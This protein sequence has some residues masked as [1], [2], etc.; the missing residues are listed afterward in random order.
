MSPLNSRKSRE[1]GALL[2][3]L[4]TGEGLGEGVPRSSHNAPSRSPSTRSS[5]VTRHSLLVTLLATGGALA[6]YN[7][8]LSWQAGPLRSALP[9]ETN[10]YRWSRTGE[11]INVFYKLIG[12]QQDVPL[13]LVHGIDA[14]ASS[15]EWRYVA[16]RL[17]ETHR[18]FAVDLPGFGLS[19][20]P[21]R[22]YS[23]ADYVDFLDDFL[24]EVVGEPAT[25]LASSLSAAY[26]IAVASRSPARVRSLLLICP[27]GLEHLAD[28]PTRWQHALGTLLRLPIV[29]TALYNVL[30]S[31]QSIGYFLCE[32]TFADPALATPELIDAYY[33][34]SHQEGARFAPAAFVS[35]ALNLS[36]REIYPSLTQPILIVWGREAKITP[37]SDANRF[38]QSRRQS[39]LKV[40]DRCGLLPHVEKPAEFLEVATKALV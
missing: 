21:S 10:F 27:T 32:R 24:R 9:G 22:A 26:A 19:D 16:G 28:P 8:W 15:G 23:A 37:V 31:R 39:R 29:G 6:A 2:S 40:L 14:A 36:V 30:V 17:T 11:R 34:T 20:R 35:G 18:V 1:R 7:T 33:R 4:P 25:L 13:V 3:P 5:L 12:K 38:I